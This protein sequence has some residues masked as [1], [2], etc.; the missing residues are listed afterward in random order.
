MPLGGYSRFAR[1]GLVA[2]LIPAS[3]QEG[4]Y[5]R[6]S[7][8]RLIILPMWIYVFPF[9]EYSLRNDRLYRIGVYLKRTDELFA[10][11]SEFVLILAT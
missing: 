5:T 11:G 6:T 9:S 1:P 3:Q 4:I 10:N 2:I 8:D 7:G